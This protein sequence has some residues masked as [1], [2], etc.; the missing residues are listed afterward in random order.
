MPN[1]KSV[2]AELHLFQIV[3][4]LIVISLIVIAE[5]VLIGENAA[6]LQTQGKSRTTALALAACV[7]LLIP[8]IPGLLVEQDRLWIQIAKWLFVSSLITMQVYFASQTAIAPELKKLA[9]GSEAE[10]VEDYKSQLAKY[11]NQI[12]VYQNHID[13]FPESFR[14]KRAE[15]SSYQLKLLED[16]RKVLDD[17]RVISQ[18]INTKSDHLSGFFQHLT[19]MI[20][21]L[22]RLA[23][24]IGVVIMTCSLRKQFSPQNT[25]DAG[26]TLQ[27]KNDYSNQRSP[28][29]ENERSPVTPRNFVLSIYPLAYCKSK[30]G[31]KGPF[32]I[33]SGRQSKIEIAKAKGTAAAWQKAAKK[34]K[35]GSVLQKQNGDSHND[36][37]K[38]YAIKS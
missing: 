11:D 6:F 33:Y 38:V 23:L 2:A 14:T 16:R 9:T 10:I 29:Q 17:L 35:T 7:A 19:I 36:P 31:R 5:I 4:T 30:N 15:L 8:V 13:S 24:E 18:K 12:Q 28:K 26:H 32:V 37:P 3:S 20:T 27:Q 22:Y 25:D 21:I 1:Y 34:L